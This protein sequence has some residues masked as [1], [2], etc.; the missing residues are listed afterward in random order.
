MSEQ[1]SQSEREQLEAFLDGQMSDAEQAAF[2]ERLRADAALRR[3][4]NLQQRIDGSLRRMFEVPRPSIERALSAVTSA[5]SAKAS[6]ATEARALRSEPPEA[7]SFRGYWI[8]AGIASAAAVAWVVA[9][10]AWNRPSGDEPYFAVRPLVDVYRDAVASG[11]EPS[12]ECREADRFAATF[13]QRQGQPLALLAMP[14]GPRMLG[15]SYVGGLTRMTT[16]MLCLVDGEPVMVFVDRADA[17]EPMAAVKDLEGL[18]IFREERDGLVFYEVTPLPE[19]RVTQLLA[20]SLS[21]AGQ[22]A[23]G[24]AA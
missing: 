24:T 9:T 3:Q 20:P 21:A 18:H 7:R 14:A 13:R 16:A 10:V 1:P 6:L 8:A 5:E 2:G 11:F 19:P 22:A 4:A 15:L 23:A 17:D 12:Y